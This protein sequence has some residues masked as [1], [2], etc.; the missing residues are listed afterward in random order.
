MKRKAC[1]L[2]LLLLGAMGCVDLARPGQLATVSGSGGSGTG[3]GGPMTDGPMAPGTGGAPGPTTDAGP[4]PS[5]DAWSMT[6][7]TGGPGDAPGAQPETEVPDTQAPDAQIP[8]TSDT[9]IPDAT[10]PDVAPEAGRVNQAPTVLAGATSTAGPAGNTSKTLSVLGAD[11][12]GEAALTYT[13]A[14]T[15]IAPGVVGFSINGANAAKSVA[16]TFDTAGTY[17]LEVIIRDAAGLSVTSSVQVQ[18]VAAA[19]DLTIS[20]TVLSVSAG[21]MTQFTTKVFDQFGDPLAN[22]IAATWQLSGDPCG[23]VSGT[24]LF[25][26]AAG[27]ASNCSLT[28]TVGSASDQASIAVDS[29]IVVV[30][31]VAD[32]YVDESNDD[33]N[34]GTSTSLLVKSQNGATNTR[35]VYLR[36]P[37]PSTS[38]SKVIFRL[39]GRSDSSTSKDSVM[40]VSDNKWAE[41]GLTWK[42]R[43]S[44]GAAR[45]QVAVTTTN[46][47][48]E[49]DVTILIR[50]ALGRGE[51]KVS[52]GLHMD[53]PTS[54]S[55]D[56]FNSREAPSNPPQ[57]VFTP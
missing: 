27:A 9:G 6:G 34:F 42:N 29:S 41:T 7:G 28:A 5:P 26:A 24:G 57:L 46:K 2:G 50:N 12:D 38:F 30:A 16:A 18:M 51:D 20:P 10:V 1:L 32:S 48:R 22:Q 49:W 53:T 44:F 43:P 47:Y 15:G 56:S 14:V 37:V 13:W 33:K 36:F 39:Y 55:P 3:G 23:T 52:F 8:G 45:G 21:S 11:D 31:P 19:N 54:N 25:T 4:D 40:E 35:E 17:N